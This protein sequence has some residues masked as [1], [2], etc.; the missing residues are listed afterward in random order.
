MGWC[1]FGMNMND[2]SVAQIEETPAE[3]RRLRL[4]STGALFSRMLGTVIILGFTGCTT[5][6]YK[7]D[8]DKE[9]Y[10]IIDSKWQDGFGHKSNYIIGDSNVPASPSDIQAEKAVPASGVIGLAQAVAIATAHNR[11]YQRQKEQLYLTALDLTLARY[12]FVRQ[13][14]GTVDAG[15]SRDADDEQVGSGAEAGFDQLL[16]DGARVSTS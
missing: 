11:E 1:D 10:Q 2:E 7:A 8:A 9:V 14:F 15:Y 16:A 6:H 5:E 4:F 3:N 13:W 12:Q